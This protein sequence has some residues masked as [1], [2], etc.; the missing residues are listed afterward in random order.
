[1]IYIYIYIFATNQEKKILYMIYDRIC[2]IFYQLI[3]SIAKRFEKNR[4]SLVGPKMLL[5]SF[6]PP[7]FLKKTLLYHSLLSKT[8]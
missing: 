2:I 4:Y 1:M 8:Y 7:K 6:Q 5:F 3:H